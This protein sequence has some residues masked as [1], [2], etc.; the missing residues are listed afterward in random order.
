MEVARGCGGFS[1]PVILERRSSETE[2]AFLLAHDRDPFNRWEA[3]RALALEVMM[4]AASAD[5]FAEALLAPD[6]RLFMTRP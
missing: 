4:G 5:A 6:Q 2:R 3:A 1:A